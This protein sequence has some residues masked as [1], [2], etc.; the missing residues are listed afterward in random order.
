[1]GAR[2]YYGYFPQKNVV[3][4]IAVNAAG[5]ATDNLGKALF[6]LYE[7]VTGEVVVLPSSPSK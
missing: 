2:V 3:I 6:A 5:A 4:V 1:M 7:A